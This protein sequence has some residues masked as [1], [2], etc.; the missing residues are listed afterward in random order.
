MWASRVVLQASVRRG[1]T[2]PLLSSRF[3]LALALICRV[4]VV[5]VVF[6]GSRCSFV[7]FCVLLLPF[8]YFFGLEMV[9]TPLLTFGAWFELRF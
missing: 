3:G 4:C 5:L 6:V 1:L 2:E 8:A 7:A 9:W